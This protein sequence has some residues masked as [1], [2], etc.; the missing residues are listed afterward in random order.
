MGDEL[1]AGEC[2]TKGRGSPALVWAAWASLGLP[3]RRQAGLVRLRFSN[4]LGTRP[5]TFDGIHVGLQRTAAALV[6]GSNQPVSFAGESAT[7]VA[8][9]SSVRSDPVTLPF[10]HDPATAELLGRKLAVSFHVVGESGP[11]TWHAK[12]MTTSYLTAPGAGAKGEGEDED[13]FP[14]STASWYFLGG[15]RGGGRLVPTLSRSS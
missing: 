2:S 3:P 1:E 15:E 5:V 13:A 7:A 8:T 12:A 4:A 14:F 6:P 10:A 11:M 9:G